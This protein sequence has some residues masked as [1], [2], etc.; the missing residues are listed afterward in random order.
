MLLAHDVAEMRIGG[1]RGGL[2]K[3]R[4]PHGGP[5]GFAC[6]VIAQFEVLPDFWRSRR[7]S[8]RRPENRVGKKGAS[9]TS[10]SPFAAST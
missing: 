1:E 4:L 5:H 10:V 7:A 8:G 3:D 9:S 2:V 6:L